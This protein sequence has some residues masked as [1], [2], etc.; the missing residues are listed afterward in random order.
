MIRPGYPGLGKKMSFAERA[1]T[2]SDLQV[3]ESTHKDDL[4][5]VWKIRCRE[6]IEGIAILEWSH[7]KPH[8]FD[9]A[10]KTME[11]LISCLSKRFSAEQ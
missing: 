6:H 8:H 11:T 3:I 10:T 4:L 1:Q 7:Y 5:W 9:R 2:L